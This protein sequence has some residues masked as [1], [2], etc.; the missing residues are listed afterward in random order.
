VIEI[1]LVGDYFGNMAEAIKGIS[2][3]VEYA[4]RPRKANL[5][6]HEISYR[7]RLDIKF[8][9]DFGSYRDLQRHRGGYCSVPIITPGNAAFHP[10][11]YE[12]LP[13]KSKVAADV[14]FSHIFRATQGIKGIEDA[15][16]HQY[17]L[18]MGTIVP[19]T[20]DYDI[21]QTL[22]VAELRSS[23]TVHATLRPIAQSMGRYLE[24]ELGVKT[25]CDFSEDAWN[26]RRGSQDITSKLV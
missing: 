24:K 12:N 21:H 18:P 9:I 13:D 4:E 3:R 1:G 22:Y 2:K 17:L 16:V 15:L 20:L 5:P 6:K 8:D 26:I 19:I 23:Q 10:W 25:Y 7:N 14:L 11:Y